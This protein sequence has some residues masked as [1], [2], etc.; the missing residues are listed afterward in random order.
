MTT[1]EYYLRDMEASGLL[2]LLYNGYRHINDQPTLENVTLET[3]MADKA[4]CKF[5]TDNLREE[6]IKGI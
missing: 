4:F 2:S 1:L 5:T 3:A 6:Y